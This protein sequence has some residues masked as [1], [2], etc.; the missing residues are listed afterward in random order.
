MSW[1]A[2]GAVMSGVGAIASA[3]GQN[4]ANKLAR[5]MAREQMAFQERM[6]NT[7]VQR[8]MADLRASGIN[9]ILAGTYDAS[10]PAGAMANVGNVGLAG[11]QGFQGVAQAMSGMQGVVNQ[12]A[13]TAAQIR[14][15]DADIMKIDQEVENLQQTQE[16]TQEQTE[17][18]RALTEQVYEQIVLTK[19]QVQL[20]TAQKEL[21]Y[22]RDQQIEYENIVGAIIAKFQQEHPT[23][24]V[25]QHYG[26]D[27]KTLTDFVG[28]T[29]GNLLRKW[30]P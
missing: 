25:L 17:N 2:A 7:A 22:S 24:T 9:P 20:T 29:I 8:R 11:V 10:T 26:V 21:A 23:L 18:V 19:E 28:G 30:K 1:Q 27:A 4:K 5:Q 14:K 6:S 13:M 3:F 16:L 15:L 12:T